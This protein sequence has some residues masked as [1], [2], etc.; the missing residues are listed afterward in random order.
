MRSYPRQKVI[1]VALLYC[2]A[3]ALICGVWSARYGL[4]AAVEDPNLSPSEIWR[5]GAR[6]LTSTEE[7]QS[8]EEAQANEETQ[9]T[10][11]PDQ[12][13]DLQSSLPQLY[14]TP[15]VFALNYKDM[16]ENLRVFIYPNSQNATYEFDVTGDTPVPVDSDSQSEVL[17][18]NLLAKRPNAFVTKDPEEAHLFF[19]PLS[20]T[21]MLTNLGPAA[22]GVHLRHYLQSIRYSFPFWDRAL[23]SDHF[24][25]TTGAYESYNHRNNL[26]FNKNAIQVARS[27]LEPQQFFYPHKDIALPSHQQSPNNHLTPER[28]S[29]LAYVG[30]PRSFTPSEWESDSDFFLESRDG[31][32]QL[33]D[34]KFCV[35][36][37][38][39]HVVDALRAGCVPVLVSDSLFYDLPFQDVLNWH[40]FAV[41]IGTSEMA[42]LKTVLTSMPETTYQKMQ[43]LGQQASKHMEWHDPPAPYDA[44]HMT[45]FQLWMRRHSVKY[46]RRAEA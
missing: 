28:R 38:M 5:A 23:G 4:S 15:Q 11:E 45:L 24:Y 20:F 12:D 8:T 27:P 13:L 1:L 39:R 30:I 40:Q 35:T 21:A 6:S 22:V 34:A 7:I 29:H 41:V 18:F 37:S 33:A 46:G 31:S 26:E 16:I 14:H 9:D 10:E 19:L 3:A 43:Y 32:A 44:F 42:S 25:L 17:F 2:C 36:D